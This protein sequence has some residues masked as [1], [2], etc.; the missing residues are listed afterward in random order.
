[1]EREPVPVGDIVRDEAT[2]QA[3]ILAF[4]IVGGVIVIWSMRAASRPDLWRT[5]R[6]KKALFVKRTA[7]AIADKCHD[8]AGKAATAYN[9]E[10]A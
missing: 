6:M 9:Q 3:V 8:I 7:N 5:L 4:S 2:R 1:M 10:R